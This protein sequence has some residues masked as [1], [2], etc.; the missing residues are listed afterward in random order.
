MATTVIICTGGSISTDVL[1]YIIPDAILIA[2]DS[3]AIFLIEH[4]FQ[5][6]IAIGDF[7]SVT[8]EQFQLIEQHSKQVISCDPIDKDFTD[9]EMAFRLAMDMQPDRII[10][11]GALGSRFDHTFA[12]VS[13]LALAAHAQIDAKI[14]D[15]NN[16]IA[17]SDGTLTIQRSEFPNLSLLPFGTAVT[18]ITLTGFQYKLE[19][20]TLNV[21]ESRGIS[22]I[23]VDTVGTIS[24]QTGRLL[25]IES[26]D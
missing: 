21:G 9:T 17:L 23:L 2:A 3:G 8:S 15:G 26:R 24:H 18:G 10:L 14:I 19:N 5:P 12:N 22:N 11:L 13:L 25:V 7:D 1:S 6:D 16:R 4:G 20:A